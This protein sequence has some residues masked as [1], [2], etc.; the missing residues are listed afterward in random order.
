MEGITI[1]I[2]QRKK[3]KR[4]ESMDEAFAEVFQKKKKKRKVNMAKIIMKRIKINFSL[5]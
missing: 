2:I 1:E 3:W 4:E 5:L